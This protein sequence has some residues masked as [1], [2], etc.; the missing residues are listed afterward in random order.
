MNILNMVYTLLFFSSKCTAFDSDILLLLKLYR[1]GFLL[2]FF[3]VIARKLLNR[4]PKYWCSF[5][6]Q[7]SSPWDRYWV[8]NFVS[9]MSSTRPICVIHSSSRPYT[10]PRIFFLLFQFVRCFF[11]YKIVL[12]QRLILRILFLLLSIFF[13]VFTSTPKFPIHVDMLGGH[14]LYRTLPFFLS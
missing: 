12:K 2:I 3:H 14:F 4:L 10:F 1:R 8:N 5:A 7:S 6:P 13:C 9:I 11:S